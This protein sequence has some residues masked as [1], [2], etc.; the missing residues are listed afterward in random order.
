MV[1]VVEVVDNDWATPDFA[2]PRK[3]D[4][5]YLKFNEVTYLSV[6]ESDGVVKEG[7]RGGIRVA[8]IKAGEV[9]IM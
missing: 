3:G 8:G 2:V 9:R 7:G 5:V 6:V 1:E 4:R